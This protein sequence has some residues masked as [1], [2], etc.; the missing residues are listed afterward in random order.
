MAER[1]RLDWLLELGRQRD[2]S[3]FERELAL[4]NRGDDL[5]VRCYAL[6]ARA[7]R[8]ERVAPEARGLLVNPPAYGEACAALMAQLAQTG[9]LSQ[10]ELLAQLRLAGEMGATGP[11]RRIALL[12]GASD[13]RAA[14][15]VD[16]PAVAMARGIGTTRAERE[17][18]LVALG[19]MARTSL[20]LASVALNKNSDKLTAEERAIGWANVAL[21]ASITLSPEA[22]D[23][24]QRAEG[25]PLTNF[26][27]EWKTRMALRRGD[28]RTVAATIESMPTP[29]RDESGWVY[30]LGRAHVAQGRRE[31]GE[32]LFRR[33]ATQ[34]NFYGQL[35]MEELG[36]LVTI[37]RPP[38]RPPRPKSMRSQRCRPCARP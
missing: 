26:Q 8:G 1:L 25:A 23:Y 29:L 13:T 22:H 10:E 6:L 35:A 16:V 31:E 15:A 33:V 14:Q 21:A 2:W 5:Q 27:R 7:M 30:W 28:W 17:I 4:V 36:E 12:L 9:Q 38:R 24:W 34:N 20:R 11:S 3:N 32:A 19:R 37:P 18:Y